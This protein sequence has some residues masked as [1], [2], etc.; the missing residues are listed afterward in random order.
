MVQQ[1][2]SDTLPPGPEADT[3]DQEGCT[4]LATLAY[5]WEWGATGICCAKHAE[6]L[7]QTSKNLKR[8]VV[9]HPRQAAAPAPLTRDEKT[10]LV[11]KAL[12][13][14]EELKA[15]QSAGQQLH[16]KNQDLQVQLSTSI[17]KTR[18]LTAQLNDQA[19][20]F[21]SVEQERDRLSAQNGEL[22]VELERLKHLDALVSERAERDAHDR[23]IEGGN[24]VDG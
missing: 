13:L 24:V 20:R 19:Q 4:A 16:S 21:Q 7:Q 6:L 3:C 12:V 9:I 23:G 18:E 8:T 17:S 15:A 5:R 22:L 11:A 1:A 2:V 14:E 10:Q